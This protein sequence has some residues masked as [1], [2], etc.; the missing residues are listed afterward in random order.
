[1][2][3]YEDYKELRAKLAGQSDE[4]IQE[5]LD[6]GIYNGPHGV[7]RRIAQGCLDQRKL[8]RQAGIQERQESREDEAGKRATVANWIACFAAATA[9]VAIVVSVVIMYRA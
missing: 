1:M 7:K 2:S 8:E 9:V 6:R 5:G 3:D 4:E